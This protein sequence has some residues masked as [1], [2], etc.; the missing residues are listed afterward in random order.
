MEATY[1]KEDGSEIIWR[2]KDF[3]DK[4]SPNFQEGKSVKGKWFLAT[5]E[6]TYVLLHLPWMR[7]YIGSRRVIVNRKRKA[8]A[9]LTPGTPEGPPQPRPSPFAA[10]SHAAQDAPH[11]ARS[12]DWSAILCTI[13]RTRAEAE[14]GTSRKPACVVRMDELDSMWDHVTGALSRH[15]QVDIGPKDIWVSMN[16]H[17][18]P[19]L[20]ALVSSETGCVMPTGLHTGRIGGGGSNRQGNFDVIVPEE[21]HALLDNLVDCFCRGVTQSPDCASVRAHICDGLTAAHIRRACRGTALMAEYVAASDKPT[22]RDR[23]L[24]VHFGENDEGIVAS[25]TGQFDRAIEGANF[26]FGRKNVVPI[27][28]LKLRVS[29]E[30][31]EPT[32]HLYCRHLFV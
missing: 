31:K 17:V 26:L 21:F 15:M 22:Q 13:H 2:P 1:K 8:T 19:V 18:S 7:D 10:S 24:R 5:T 28:E 32:V 20:F 14:L 25:E 9:P 4:I 6:K 30:T 3:I 29:V 23:R 12:G 16:L 11:G 27:V